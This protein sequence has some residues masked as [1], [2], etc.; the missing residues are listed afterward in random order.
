MRENGRNPVM[1]AELLQGGSFE[2]PVNAV[3]EIWF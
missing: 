2:P 1:V 3:A